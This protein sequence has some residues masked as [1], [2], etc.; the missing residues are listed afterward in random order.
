LL[1]ATLSS[2]STHECF[3]LLKTGGRLF[4]DFIAITIALVQKDGGLKLR[5]G[6]RSTYMAILRPRLHAVNRR[7]FAYSVQEY[8]SASN[9]GTLNV[10]RFAPK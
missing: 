2:R 3:E 8:S 9:S 4:S 5:L 1:A 6:M 7:L 10:S